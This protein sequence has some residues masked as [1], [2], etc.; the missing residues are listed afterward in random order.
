MKKPH[1][2]LF[3]PD[4]MRADAMGHLGNPAAHTPFL[5]RMAETDAVSFRRAFCQN[6]VCVPSRCSF[7]TGLYPHVHG[8]RTMSYLLRE[9]E[10]SLLKELKEQGYYVWMNSRNDLAAGQVPGLFESHATEVYYSG[11]A[12]EAPG[13][14]DD[15]IRGEPGGKQFYSFYSGRLKT[16]GN[17]RNYTN[18]EE[19]VDAAIDRIRN[20]RDDRPLCM[21]LGLMYPHPPYKV[22]E[23]YY[24][25]PKDADAWERI[26]EEECAGK[27]RMEELLRQ[28]MNLGGYTQEDWNRLR[29]CY[30]GMCSKVDAL[31]ARL[32]NALKE[33]G[34]YDDCAIF[35]FS[36]HGDYTGDYGLSEKA[37]NTFEDCLTNVPLLIK[38]PA[39]FGT[40]AGVA[41]GLVELVD[42]YAT[43]LSFAGARPSHTHFGRS[44][45]PVLQDR[46][47]C[48]RDYV[49]C[50]GG[51]LEEETHCDEYHESMPDERNYYYPRLKA[52]TDPVAHGKA[53][54]IRSKRY[55]Y[56][57][58][59]YERDELYDLV[60]DPGERENVIGEPAYEADLAVLKEALLDWYQKTADVVPFDYDERFGFDI[61]WNRVKKIC[62][63]ERE[64]EVKE[65]IRQGANLFE[66]VHYCKNLKSGTAQQRNSQARRDNSCC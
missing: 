6:P 21:F 55:K 49:F 14:E 4:Q 25:M 62:P 38:P 60:N 19:D 12:G 8:H 31:F 9:G 17:G 39:G 48:G 47:S 45:E 2:I 13:P 32:C 56:I 57:R 41:D 37:Q 59:I 11:A 1:I 35:F 22:E 10:T 5:D 51:R 15:G 18:D 64:A 26:P 44:L 66:L 28:G 34:I 36:D 50:E 61:R 63:P 58:R 42:L 33:E 23:P 30:L 43:A 7:F 24:S 20:R 27:P 52:Q 40:D 3:N 54:M 16:D 29:H 53:A 46:K 65:K